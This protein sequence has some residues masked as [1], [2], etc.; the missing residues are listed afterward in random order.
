MVKKFVSMSYLLLS[1]LVA[2]AEADFFS[3]GTVPERSSLVLLG[4]GNIAAAGA[5]G[6]ASAHNPWGFQGRR[7]CI[8]RAEFG[9]LRSRGPQRRRSDFTVFWSGYEKS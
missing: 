7:D 8:D 5:P 9:E 3:A 4:T 1:G 2:S 6:D